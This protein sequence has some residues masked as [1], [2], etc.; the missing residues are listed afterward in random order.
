VLL[1][2]RDEARL[3]AAN[4]AGGASDA[5]I[6]ASNRA[7]AFRRNLINLREGVG[8]PPENTAESAAQ[9]LPTCHEPDVWPFL[10]ISW[11]VRV[12]VVVVVLHTRSPPPLELV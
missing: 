11:L 8:N 1:V 4:T 6:A 5:Q 10:V 3:V 12:A 7:M 2:A 9:Q